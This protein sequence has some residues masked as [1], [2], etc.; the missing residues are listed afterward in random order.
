M[1]TRAEIKQQAKEQLKGNV[2]M[3]FLCAII[4]AAIAGCAGMIQVV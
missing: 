3:F 1:F 4:V 2:W